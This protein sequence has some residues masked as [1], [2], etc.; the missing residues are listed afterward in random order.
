MKNFPMAFPFA[1]EVALAKEPVQ[2]PLPLFPELSDANLELLAD[3]CSG[4]ACDEDL[5]NSPFKMLDDI[6]R[7]G[8][9]NIAAFKD[10]AQLAASAGMSYLGCLTSLECDEVSGY[11]GLPDDDDDDISDGS[12]PGSRVAHEHASSSAAVSAEAFPLALT[13]DLGSHI[14]NSAQQER[15]AAQEA[16]QLAE[17]YMCGGDGDSMYVASAIAEAEL[18]YQMEEA[19][20]P[21]EATAQLSLPMFPDLSAA[22][23]KPHDDLAASLDSHTADDSASEQNDSSTSKA[24]LQQQQQEVEPQSASQVAQ[25]PFADGRANAE[26][27]SASNQQQDGED[28]GHPATGQWPPLNAAAAWEGALSRGGAPTSGASSRVPVGSISQSAACPLI[29]NNGAAGFLHSCCEDAARPASAGSPQETGAKPGI[30]TSILRVA[31]S[32]PAALEIPTL[33]LYD[34]PASPAGVMS[35]HQ[36]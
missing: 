14:S 9:D 7:P 33:F 6:A 19:R 2:Q 21:V 34:E 15:E 36:V 5:G 3:A 25:S 29:S 17:G 31:L 22:A 32:A 13:G 23:D 24:Q 1:M 18:L 30:E 27:S 35:S 16:Q 11:D 28:S 20:M 10:Q 12:I 26:P 4:L 8:T